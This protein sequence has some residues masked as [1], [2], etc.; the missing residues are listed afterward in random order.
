MG[1][2]SGKRGGAGVFIP[3]ET[4]GVL[5]AGTRVSRE[6]GYGDKGILRG[7]CAYDGECSTHKTSWGCSSGAP[8]QDHFTFDATTRIVNLE[9]P[10]GKRMDLN[11]H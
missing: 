3:D 6:T 2:R 5:A 9:F 1:F 10:L 11:F 8:G 4:D 7:S